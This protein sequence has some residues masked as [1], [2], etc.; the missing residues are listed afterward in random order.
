M[1]DLWKFVRMRTLIRQ[2]DEVERSIK[3]SLTENI[4]QLSL[5]WLKLATKLNIFLQTNKQN[6]E[7]G[8]P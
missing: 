3:M 1:A 4:D 5:T 2:G 6:K 7:F 8:L